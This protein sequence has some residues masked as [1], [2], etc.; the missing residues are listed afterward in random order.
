MDKASKYRENAGIAV[1]LAIASA[2]DDDKALLLQVAQ[3]WLDLA[4][5]AQRNANGI[6]AWNA[7]LEDA[8]FNQRKQ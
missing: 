7:V 1:D 6:R 8:N 5:R 4:Q 2:N 3:G